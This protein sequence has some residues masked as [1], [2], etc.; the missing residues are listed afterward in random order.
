MSQKLT[1]DERLDKYADFAFDVATLV[2]A[3]GEA[4]SEQVKAKAFDKVGKRTQEFMR[5]VQ[6]W[7]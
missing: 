3:Y 4:D 2:R 1:I 5:E 7:V 6:S